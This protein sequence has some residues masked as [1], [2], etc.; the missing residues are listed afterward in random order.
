VVV[1]EGVVVEVEAGAMVHATTS[2]ASLDGGEGVGSLA[3]GASTE[4]EDGVTGPEGRA[5]WA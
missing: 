2:L 4:D 5:G 1:A 3:H